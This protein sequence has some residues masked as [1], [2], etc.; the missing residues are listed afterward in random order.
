MN[1]PINLPLTIHVTQED[2]DEGVQ[3]DCERCPVARAVERAT[4]IS[5]VV[6]FERISVNCQNKVVFVTPTYVRIFIKAFDETRLVTPF[7]FTLTE[8]DRV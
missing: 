8:N 3:E 5:T 7:S 6:Q 2:I 4:G 1:P